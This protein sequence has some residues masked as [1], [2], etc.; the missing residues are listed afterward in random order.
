MRTIHHHSHKLLQSVTRLQ[1]GLLRGFDRLPLQVSLPPFTLVFLLACTMSVLL[2]A[3]VNRADAQFECYSSHTMP[4]LDT[5]GT[6]NVALVYVTFP[7]SSGDPIPDPTMPALDSERTQA[8]PNA[9][10]E[11]FERQSDGALILNLDTVEV[12]GDPSAMWLAD[13]PKTVYKDPAQVVL[14]DPNHSS[15]YRGTPGTEEDGE[16]SYTDAE[17]SA[18]ILEKIVDAYGDP[19]PVSSADFLVMIYSAITFAPLAGTSAQPGGWAGLHLCVNSY[20]HPCSTSECEDALPT[21]LRGVEIIWHANMSMASALNVLCHEISHQLPF[22]SRID[23]DED[24]HT[25]SNWFAES[26]GQ[27]PTEENYNYGNLS[28]MRSSYVPDEGALSIILPELVKAGWEEVPEVVDESRKSYRLYDLRSP[29]GH[30]L[31]VPIVQ[32]TWTDDESIPGYFVDYLDLQS[33]WISY[34]SGVSELG[35]PNED[36][37]PAHQ[38]PSSSVYRSKGLMAWHVLERRNGLRGDPLK[39]LKWAFLDFESADGRTS[40]PWMG[41]ESPADPERGYDPYDRW[42]EPHHATQTY[43]QNYNGSSTDFFTSDDSNPDAKSEFSYRS[44]PSAFGQLG[45]AFANEIAGDVSVVDPSRRAP[46][47]VPTSIMIEVLAEGVDTN[48]VPYA[49]LNILLAP[50]ENVLTPEPGQVVAPGA[51]IDIV[52][53]QDRTHGWDPNGVWGQDQ[54]QVIDKYEVF[55]STDGGDT[56]PYDLTQGVPHLNQGK[57]VWTPGPQ[58]IS[59]EAILKVRFHNVFSDEVGEDETDAPFVIAYPPMAFQNKSV[60]TQMT[61]E[62]QPY[63]SVAF[64]ANGLGPQDLMLAI[65]DQNSRLYQCI[66]TAGGVPQFDLIPTSSFDSGAS[67][68]QAALH[69]L[70][71]ADYDNDGDVDLFAAAELSPR[72]YRNEGNLTFTDVAEEVG[73]YDPAT[74]DLARYSWCGAWQDYDGDGLLDLFVGR[75]SGGGTE[76]LPGGVSNLEDVLFKGSLDPVTGAFQFTDVTAAANIDQDPN[77]TDFTASAA[78]GDINGDG[79]P[80]LFQARL[81]DNLP[82]GPPGGPDHGSH[83]YINQGDGTF[84][85]ESDLWIASNINWQSGVAWVDI[86]ND[87]D[88]DLVSSIQG[89]GVLST[90]VHRNDGNALTLV[91]ENIGLINRKPMK[92]ITTLDADLDGNIDLL[93]IPESSTKAPSLYISDGPAPGSS[94]HD[95][96][97]AAGLE[98]A[99]TSGLS[100]NDWNGDGDFDMYLGRE[101][102]G[103]TSK[104]YY[105]ATASSG[106]DIP[107][108]QWVSI[109]LKGGGANNASG[110]GA[111]IT[112]KKN[113]VPF[114]THTVDGGSGRGGQQSS[115]LIVGLGDYASTPPLSAEVRWPN[116]HVQSASLTEN[117]VNVFQDSTPVDIQDASISFSKTAMPGSVLRLTFGWTTPEYTRPQEDAVTIT[118]GNGAGTYR[119]SVP[120]V[121]HKV[122]Q[123]SGGYR[124]VLIIDNFPCE[125]STAYNYTVHSE[126]AFMTDNGATKMFM[127][128][129]CIQ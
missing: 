62:G 114:R 84:V 86:D 39:P 5:E 35:G 69:G 92:S 21:Q 38:D 47:N 14:L 97:L 48:G 13:H 1:P 100:V 74:P 87:N 60:E 121:S 40:D 53:T 123:V 4:A 49:D 129:V 116:G 20:L 50:H 10:T 82:V 46:Q 103:A 93:A 99:T 128:K 15:C 78:W 42:P 67:A 56:F 115:D 24:P 22:L 102:Q 106:A 94:F 108:N 27:V 105:R 77:Q 107:D 7:A 17:L 9:V 81:I 55:L 34:H 111:T 11:F 95:A 85:E 73:L 91:S 58:H 125:T 76:P 23:A 33:F 36:G 28:L 63:S 109:R 101:E 113:G 3:V 119:P 71:A 61:Y 79:Y 90:L 12:P 57:F 16:R 104:F 32:N 19:D 83:L 6:F 75:G 30:A 54:L 112:V 65:Q 2:A 68:P 72:L 80:D 64:D 89:N 29:E 44:N 45:L 122:T 8:L 59:D 18:E 98:P 51:P 120:N 127:N 70:A 66:G 52:W 37:E 110:I 43:W 124:H 26:V 25:P 31:A 96:G 118:G 126:T 88:L 117:S 41:S